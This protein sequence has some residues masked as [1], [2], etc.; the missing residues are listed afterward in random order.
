[1]R[2]TVN[3][4]IATLATTTTAFAANAGQGDEPGILCWAFLGFCAI[5]FAGQL[6]PAVMLMVGTG[7]LTR[8]RQGDSDLQA[9]VA[10]VGTERPIEARLTGGF[11]YGALRSAVRSGESPVMRISPD[12]AACSRREATTA[13]AEI[14]N[15]LL[16]AA[17]G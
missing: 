17:A 15:T 1:M 10:A 7:G 9:L 4:S 16:T 5:I 11:A 13:P 12:V 2:K 14:S 6:V 8:W 3:T